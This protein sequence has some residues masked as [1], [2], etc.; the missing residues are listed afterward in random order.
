MARALWLILA[1]ALL[2]CGVD[3]DQ[4]ANAS[5]VH[6]PFGV[7]SRQDMAGVVSKVARF[8]PIFAV[9]VIDAEGFAWLYGPACL[10]EALRISAVLE[11]E[12]AGGHVPRITIPASLVGQGLTEK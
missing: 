12:A 3:L 4:L 5:A 7:N 6:S 9:E 2:D 11:R 10:D 8:A 1:Q